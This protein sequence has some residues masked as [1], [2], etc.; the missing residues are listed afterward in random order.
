LNIGKRVSAE[1]GRKK[2]P[3]KSLIKYFSMGFALFFF[4]KY[5]QYSTTLTYR[6]V[7]SELPLNLLG[8]M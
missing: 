6:L 1:R 2:K 5:N 7:S 8:G 4:A 3:K